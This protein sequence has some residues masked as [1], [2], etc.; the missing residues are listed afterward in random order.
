MVGVV[1]V[2]LSCRTVDRYDNSMIIFDNFVVP[3]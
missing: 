2:V 1:F 3:K